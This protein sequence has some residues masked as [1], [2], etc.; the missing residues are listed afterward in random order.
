[1][2][3]AAGTAALPLVE[4]SSA[5][6]VATAATSARGGAESTRALDR[7]AAR[8]DTG[9]GR[10]ASVTGVA[11]E[12]TI[13]PRGALAAG[14]GASSVPVGAGVPA[15]GADGVSPTGAGAGSA[16]AVTGSGPGAGSEAA[17]GTAGG[18]ASAGDGGTGT[19][20][21]TAVRCGKNANGSR[22]PCASAATRT[23]R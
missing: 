18:A 22:Y 13:V 21:G 9:A 19:G 15:A 2:R 12:T 3:P 6:T 10:P 23:P 16:G 11:A 5:P 20:G 7:W 17:A 4:S 8:G 1:M 14:A